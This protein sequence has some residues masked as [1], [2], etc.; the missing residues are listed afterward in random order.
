ME[1]LSALLESNQFLSGGATLMLLGTVLA[2]LRNVPK[3]LLVFL[4][5]KFTIHV[6]IREKEAFSWLEEWLAEHTYGKT[7]K[8]LSAAVTYPRGEAPELVFSPGR[9]N[10]LLR[11]KK[12]WVWLSR[13]KDDG[14]GN[15]KS[16]SFED[17]MNRE[18][19]GLQTF[20][21]HPGVLKDLMEEAKSLAI[22]KRKD[23]V[24]VYFNDPWGSWNRAA[25]T[26]PRKLDSVILEEGMKE[27]LVEDVKRFFDR[28]EWYVDTGIPYRRGYL[29]HGPPGCGKSSLVKGLASEFNLDLY[30][31]N[32][33]NSKFNDDKLL[34]ALH[35][36]KPGAI[37]LLEDIDAIF[38][39]REKNKKDKEEGG[40]TFSGLL[41]ALDGVAAQEGRVVFMTTNHKEKLDPALI[42]AGRA[43]VHLY[44]GLPTEDQVSRLFLHFFPGEEALAKVFATQAQGKPMAL[45]QNHLL[46]WSHSAEQAAEKMVVL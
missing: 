34:S 16:D 5:R 21:R 28:E 43:D 15:K 2:T 36:A 32:L 38:T 35:D 20:G 18:A 17:I 1:Y 7:C 23:T 40:V 41:N 3:R 33:S 4:R 11:Y 10:H 6:E 37:I 39:Q 14:A 26:R 8:L 29:L 31:V 46:S 19:F 9:G 45:L 44:I 42:R 27:T 25:I 30:V 12:R 22:A 13:S 24:A